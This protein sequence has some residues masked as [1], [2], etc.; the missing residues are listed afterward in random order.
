MI[1]G[2]WKGMKKYL[3]QEMLCDSLKG[4]VQYDF[5][6]YP[7][8]GGNS[9]VFTV[10]LD[11]QAV[12]KFGVGIVYKTLTQQ[13]YNLKY[14][15]DG[16]YVPFAERNDFTDDE[17]SEALKAYRNQSITESIH[18]E[19]PIV[20]MFA[21]VDRRIGRR[22]LIKLLGTVDKQPEWLRQF[23]E[24]RFVSEGIHNPA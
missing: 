18:S 13:G 22:T 5:T 3:E 8:F 17:F 19:N 9:A 24:I 16:Y 7:K 12:K 2:S 21:I 10:C 6:W 20:R 14:L 4:R 1:E 11:D 23:Y 15:D